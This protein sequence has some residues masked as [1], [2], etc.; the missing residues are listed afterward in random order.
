[1]YGKPPGVEI[2]ELV[3]MFHSCKHT[4]RQ[5]V[6]DHAHLIK[7]YLD[8]LATINYAFSDKVSISFILN[9]HSSEFQAFV[10]NYN[11]QSLK[12]T[13]SEVR[14]LLIEFEKIFKRNKQPIV[15]ASSTP[16][17]MAIQ[18]G[19]VQKY[20]PQ[21][22][23]KKKGKGKAELMKKKKKTRGQNVASTSSDIYT[24]DLFAFPKNSWVYD[25]GC[26]T[27][28]CKTKHGLR[29]AKKLKRGSLYLYVG[30]GVRAK[31]EA[32]EFFNLVLPNGLIIMLDSCHYAPS[33]T[34]G[35]VLVS[36]LVDK[37]FTQ[38][39]T[40]FRLSVS[41]NNM[42]YFNVITVNGIYEINM[43]DSTLPIIN[44]MY[45][46]SNKRTKSNLDSTYLWHCRLAHIN[47]KHIK[48]LQ[49]DRLL[50][51]TDNEPFDQ[52]VSFISGKMIRKSF[53]HK[54]EKVK[55]V[56]GLIHTDVCGPFRHVSKKGASYF[57]TFTDDY[58]RCGYV[59]LLK[60]KHN[61]VETFKVSI[62]G[63]KQ[64]SKSRNKRFDE[65][66]KKFSFYQNLEEPCVYQ[67]ASGSNVIFLILY[68]DDIILMGNHIPSLEEVKTYLGKCF[69]MKD[70]REAAFIL[71]IKIYKLRSR[72]SIGL[73]QNAYLNK[74][75]KRYRMDNS[76]RGSIPICRIH[77]VCCETD[78]KNI[79]KYLRNIK[80]T[81]LVYGGDPEAELRVNCY[82]DAGFETDRDDTKSQTGYVFILNGGAVVWKS[83]KQSTT[84]QHVTE[85]EYLAAS[86]AAKE[87]VWIR[88]FIDKLGV[89]PSNNYLIKMNC[90][91][92][93]AI[94]MA[95]ESGI[96]K[97]AKQFKRK[98]HY[99]CEC[100]E[101]GAI[102]IVKVHTC[103]NLDDQCTKALAGPK[104]TR[105]ARSM[106]LRLA[107]SFMYL[108]KGY[109]LTMLFYELKYLI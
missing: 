107:S 55:G 50:K 25:I 19:R 13:I 22:K 7:S 97:G 11:M 47:K 37:G 61:V 57:I 74:I 31:V 85:A 60:H 51:S 71:G 95:K 15:G 16:Q 29:G 79:L 58:G 53:S 81:F 3:N 27:H 35:V 109:C 44:S 45:S 68:V 78:A 72:R 34:R 69:F 1:M 89:V 105:H 76:K 5:S 6:S 88:K 46:I 42:S 91:N 98:Y 103:D 106:G 28:V 63:L 75:L 2:Q 101:T 64:A 21:G 83:F 30:N 92:S 65:E 104:L 49:H 36:H 39:F 43:Y 33:I 8:Q 66:I 14:S 90:D 23:A 73:S 82:C 102:H 40:D 26:G 24:I 84:V 93:A 10:Q 87:A 96:Q 54:N 94:I 32:I 52:C 59:Y 38:Y 80:D 67:K 9:S 56:L 62:Y 86:K 108:D 99:V 18:G 4:E 12:K 77:Y 20:K 100:I 41:M 17:V 48:K 70:L